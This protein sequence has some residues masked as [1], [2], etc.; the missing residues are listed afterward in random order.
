MKYTEINQTDKSICSQRLPMIH[1]E[2]WGLEGARVT[3]GGGWEDEVLAS[4]TATER[5]V[6]LKHIAGSCVNVQVHS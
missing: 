1:P 2:E 6:V 5:K 4:C 3:R